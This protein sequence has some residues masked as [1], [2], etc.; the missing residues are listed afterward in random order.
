MTANRVEYE[1]IGVIHTPFETPA[2]MPI[3]PAGDDAAIGTVEVDEQYGAG[4]GDLEE[5]SHCFLLYHFHASDDDYVLHV[6]PFLDETERGLFA[7]RAPRRPNPIG[8]SVVKIEERDELTLTVDGI[9][10]VDSTPLLDIKPYVPD[11]DVPPAAET[12]WLEQ[13]SGEVDSH[14]ADDRFL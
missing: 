7:T 12:G 3:Q 6:E 11:F 5:F 13:H 14:H 9:D 4:L 2:G 10:V 8:L 1:P